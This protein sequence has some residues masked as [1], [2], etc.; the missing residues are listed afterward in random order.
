MALWISLK[1]TLDCLRGYKSVDIIPSWSFLLCRR[2]DLRPF[3]PLRVSASCLSALFHPPTPHSAFL[4]SSLQT[5]FDIH[6]TRICLWVKCVAKGMFIILQRL[7]KMQ[8][9][10]SMA[11]PAP[12]SSDVQERAVPALLSVQYSGV[13]YVHLIVQQICRT[14]YLTELKLIIPPFF[15][16]SLSPS[17]PAPA[18]TILSLLRVWLF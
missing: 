12:T 5:H 17:P 18:T 11:L 13:N 3:V 1:G 15:L 4:S 8:F 6:V 14:F 2:S 9:V 7:L 10:S 16:P